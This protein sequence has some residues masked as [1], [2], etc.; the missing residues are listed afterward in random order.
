VM[1]LSAIGA[2]HQARRL[3]ARDRHQRRHP[4]EQPGRGAD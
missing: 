4:G 2:V 3:R 1:I